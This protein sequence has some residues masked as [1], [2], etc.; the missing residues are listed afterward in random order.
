[1]KGR[2]TIEIQVHKDNWFWNFFASLFLPL[3]CK[4]IEIECDEMELLYRVRKA[5]DKEVP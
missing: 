5:I 1:M 2:Y 4:K 3:W